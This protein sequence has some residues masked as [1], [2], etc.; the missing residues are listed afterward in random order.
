MFANHIEVDRTV[1]KLPDGSFTIDCTIQDVS[2][3]TGQMN[4][5]DH[6]DDEANGLEPECDDGMICDICNRRLAST[7][8]VEDPFIKEIYDRSE[9]SY[10][11]KKCYRDRLDDI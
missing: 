1:T 2:S 6:S 9:E 8:L 7:E 5:D 3:L 11:C 4:N 10:M